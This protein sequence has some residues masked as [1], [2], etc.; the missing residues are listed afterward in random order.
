MDWGL[1]TVDR[2][3]LA[4]LSR[5]DLAGYVRHGVPEV[6]DD[7]YLAGRSVTIDCGCREPEISVSSVGSISERVSMVSTPVSWTAAAAGANTSRPWN[8]VLAGSS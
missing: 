3:H 7:E 2:D 6:I 4:E 1:N 8:V 5:E